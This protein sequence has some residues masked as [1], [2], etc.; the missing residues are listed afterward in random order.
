MTLL[1]ILPVRRAIY[2]ALRNDEALNAMVFGI[3]DHVPQGSAYP[4]IALGETDCRD[5]SSMTCAGSEHRL[6]IQVWSREGGQAQ[7]LEIL[8]RLH[9][10]LH[11][12]N[13]TI[14][15]QTLVMAHFVMAQVGLDTDGVTYCGKMQFRLLLETNSTGE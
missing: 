1:R 4:F 9:A 6:V 8:E 11:D 14:E 13:L 2:D 10:T 3:Y 5:W 12:A 7:C 15:G